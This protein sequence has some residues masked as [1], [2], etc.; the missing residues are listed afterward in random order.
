MLAGLRTIRRVVHP[1]WMPKNP[2]ESVSPWTISFLAWSHNSMV[3]RRRPVGGELYTS[4]QPNVPY[5]R[6]CNHEAVTG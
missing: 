3:A 6:V 1:R 2:K 5:P 4:A